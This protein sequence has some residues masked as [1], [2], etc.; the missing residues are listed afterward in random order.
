VQH[1]RSASED[2]AMIGFILRNT[3]SDFGTVARGVCRVGKGNFLECVTEL[4]SIRRHGES[5]INTD[6]TGRITELSGSELVSMN[7]WGF[8]PHIFDQLQWQF[9]QFLEEV[10][11]GGGS[12]LK[13]EC[14]L[15]SAVNALVS[16]GDA[17][18]KVLRTPDA[19]FGVTYREDHAHV[20]AS[21]SQLIRE[22]TYPE[23]LWS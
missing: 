13:S 12:D 2:Y 23:R 14:Y 18:V 7:M 22:G 17:R 20:V 4:T 19:W 6:S 21:I 9:R 8:T 10:V 5:A 16:S 15:P 3:L 1:L 11:E